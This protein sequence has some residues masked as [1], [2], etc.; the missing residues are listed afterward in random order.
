[1]GQRSAGHVFMPDKFVFPGGRVDPADSRVRPA[2]GLRETVEA[3]L[4]RGCTPARARALAMAAVRETFEETGLI[5][6]TPGDGPRRSRSPSWAAFLER[7][8]LPDLAPL[9][10]IAR[11]ITPPANPRRFDA[12]FFMTDAST[13]QGEVH[14]RP[15]GSGEL[16]HLH[17]V[18]LAEA[19]QLDLPEITRL[20]IDEIAKRL[21][22]PLTNT[23]P[24]P[25]Y[26]WDGARPALEILP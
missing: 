19:K 22:T 18:P 7:G 23:V 25:F 2:R 6:G 3:R 5:V 4:V 20:V 10:F 26:R 16:V 13:I 9:E 1:M 14:E 21:Q 24:V 17:W 11:A 15:T 12:R 8:V